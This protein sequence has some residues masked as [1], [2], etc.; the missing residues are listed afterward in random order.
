MRSLVLLF[1]LFLGLT[2][3]VVQGQFVPSPDPLFTPDPVT[4]PSTEEP[5]TPERDPNELPLGEECNEELCKL[6]DCRCST[7]DIP[8]GLLPRNT[9]QFVTITFDDAIN[10]R[11]IETYRSILYGRKNSNGCPSGAT[12]FVSHEYTDYV[13][14][15]EL[16]NHGYEIA[17]NS[18]SHRTPPDYWATANYDVIKEEIADQRIQIAHFAN[19]S[20][21]SVKGVRLPF[22]QLAGNASFQVMADYGLEY[23]SSWPTSAYR[24]PGL[25]PY[26]LDYASTQDCTMPPCPTASIPKP[27]VQPLVSWTDLQGLPC[28]MA[29]SCHFTPDLEDEEAWYKF[30]VGNFERHYF[31]NRAPFGFHIHEWYLSSNPAVQAAFVRFM[32]L[33]SN[34]PDAFVVNSSEVLEWVKNP[35][36]VDV[37]RA[38]PC[39]QWSPRI[40]FSRDCGPLAGEHNEMIY[41]FNVCNVCPR[42]YP[43]TGN[44]LGR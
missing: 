13:L 30:I 7:T 41:W 39:R 2:I 43:W 21:E 9:P 8:G 34:L 22:L 14:V 6:P 37:Y 12:F 33:I 42:V 23:D 10:V 36:P 18:I 32:N 40:C 19:I 5:T 28:V 26:T 27:W 25:W 31:S 35:V 24:D 20:T 15:N 44:P 1:Y 16:Y 17:L 3:A 11:N 38:K 4:E 29:D